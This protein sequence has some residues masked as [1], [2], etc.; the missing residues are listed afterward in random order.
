MIKRKIRVG[1]VVGNK[2]EKTVVVAV[3]W[4]RAHR[5]Y[6]KRIRRIS[7]FKAHDEENRCRVGDE[8]QIIETRPL[9]KTKRWRVLSIL[10]SHEIAEV[11]PEEI[12]LPEDEPQEVAEAEP[13]AEAEEP[14]EVAEA[15]PTAE[16]EE[17]EEVAEAEPTAEAEEPEE[18]AEAEPTAE[19]EEPEEARGR[20]DGGG[21][22]ARRGSRGRTDGG[23][24]GT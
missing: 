18:V 23:G 16:A 3:E 2:M 19:V 10:K 17:P 20:T 4:S 22:G 13:T 9:S 11:K 5:L 21:R 12:N 24:R 14:E 15:E 8:V 6:K 7:R 1:R